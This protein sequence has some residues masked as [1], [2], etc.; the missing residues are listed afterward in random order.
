MGIA[1]EIRECTDHS[2]VTKHDH[3]AS[4]LA[5]TRASKIQMLFASYH[6]MPFIPPP[7][8]LPSAFILPSSLYLPISAEGSLSSVTTANKSQRSSDISKVGLMIVKRHVMDLAGNLMRKF[9]NSSFCMANSA[10]YISKSKILAAQSPR[11]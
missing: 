8:L 6:H 7:C 5:R 4:S 1:A 9:S 2:H 11:Y 3:A 10:S